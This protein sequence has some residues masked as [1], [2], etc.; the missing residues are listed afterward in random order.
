VRKIPTETW[1]IARREKIAAE[2]EY[3]ETQYHHFSDKSILG[4]LT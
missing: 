1:L 4:M 2:C 3:V